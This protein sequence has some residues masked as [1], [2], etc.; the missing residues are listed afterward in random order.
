MTSWPQRSGWRAVS[1]SAGRYFEASARNNSSRCVA[2]RTRASLVRRKAG[3]RSCSASPRRRVFDSKSSARALAS[4]VASRKAASAA[5]M[6]SSYSRI[7]PWLEEALSAHHTHT[8]RT[9]LLDC[10]TFEAVEEIALRLRIQRPMPV[11]NRTRLPASLSR[12]RTILLAA[13][14]AVFPARHSLPPRAAHPSVT[15][16][17]PSH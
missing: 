8:F 14:R 11:P 17:Q 5:S 6:Y 9:P 10:S 4:A 13:P 3:A 1:L 16:S 7:S 2:T 15:R 12:P